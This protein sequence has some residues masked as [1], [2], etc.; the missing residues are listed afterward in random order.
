[1]Y[2]TIAIIYLVAAIFLT[3]IDL[4]KIQ[5][6]LTKVKKVQKNLLYSLFKLQLF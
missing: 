4:M 2:I 5:E 6:E 3:R 1:M